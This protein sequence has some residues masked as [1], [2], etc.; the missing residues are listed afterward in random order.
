MLNLAPVGD[1]MLTASPW[2]TRG[3]VQVVGSSAAY[4]GV[5]GV[6]RVIDRGRR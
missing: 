6:R 1:R 5:S 3:P 4:C 2:C